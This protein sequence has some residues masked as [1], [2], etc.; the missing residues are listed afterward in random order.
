MWIISIEVKLIFYSIVLLSC[1]WTH[2]K[3]YLKPSQKLISTSSQSSS[4]NNKHQHHEV[5]G[6]P[7]PSINFQLSVQST[8]GPVGHAITACSSSSRREVQTL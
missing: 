8:K 1:Q 2:L 7:F 3:K 5:P 4:L 6:R